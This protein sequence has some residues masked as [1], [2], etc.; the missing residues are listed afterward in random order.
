MLLLSIIV[1]AIQA[2][3]AS[4]QSL[5]GKA[6]RDEIVIVAKNDPAMA[7]TMQ[8]ARD[9]LDGFLKLAATPPAGASSF[10]VKVAIRDGNDAEYF[11]ITPFTPKGETFSGK[12]NNSPRTVRRSMKLGDTLTFTKAEIVDWMYVDKGGMKGNY[13]ACALMKSPKDRAAFKQRFGLDCD[14]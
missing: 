10:S 8:K 7:A 3:P 5:M 6:E 11:W 1:A 9:S 14:R 12:L 4:A 13:T 2:S